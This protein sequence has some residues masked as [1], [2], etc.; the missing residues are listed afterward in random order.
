MPGYC[1]AGTVG[2]KVLNGARK[3]EME[4]KQIVSLFN[5]LYKFKIGPEFDQHHGKTSYHI[6]LSMTG[7]YSSREMSKA[8]IHL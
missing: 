3:I 5:R 8:L 7:F 6:N 1:V 4:N 2:H